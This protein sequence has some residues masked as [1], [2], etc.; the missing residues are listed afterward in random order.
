MHHLIHDVGW[1][2]LALAAVLLIVA[3]PSL[4]AWI[5]FEIQLSRRVR[6]YE[7]RMEAARVARVRIP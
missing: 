1:P 3:L 7:E 5:R 2:L 6:R 4:A